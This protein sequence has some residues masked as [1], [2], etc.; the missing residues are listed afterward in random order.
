MRE[1]EAKEIISLI[2]DYYPNFL[3]NDLEEAKKK[4][5]SWKERITDW[6]YKETLANVNN[7]IDHSIYEPRI[8]EIRPVE[9]SDIPYLNE[10]DVRDEL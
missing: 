9:K 2:A 10:R 3:P 1:Q 5:N 6:D 4:A 7:H 8:A